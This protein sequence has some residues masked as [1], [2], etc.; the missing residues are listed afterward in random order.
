MSSDSA[1]SNPLSDGDY[2][3]GFPRK[4][5]AAGMLFA[6]EERQVLL[7][8]PTYK[9]VW[10]IPGGVV[11]A[12]EAPR[13]ASIRE[14][15]EEIGLQVSPGRLLSIDYNVKPVQNHE[16]LR[17]I[18]WGGLLTQEQIDAIVL[19]AEELSEFGFFSIEDARRLLDPS[20]VQQ[21]AEILDTLDDDVTIYTEHA[22]N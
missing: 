13:E 20:L 12:L 18:F 8:N 6:N 4:V 21:L 1:N 5:V 11:E 2:S 15:E 9:E 3:Q 7:V 17:F 10:E 14:V 16:V 22:P 19:Q